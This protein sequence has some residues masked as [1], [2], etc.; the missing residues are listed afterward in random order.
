MLQPGEET[1]ACF[2]KGLFA[3]GMPLND[4]NAP[5]YRRQLEKLGPAQGLD[6]AIGERY[7][8]LGRPALLKDHPKPVGENRKLVAIMEEAGFVR[9]NFLV[10]EIGAK[11][12]A[13]IF[14]I[15]LVFLQE[16]PGVPLGDRVGGQDY[17]VVGVSS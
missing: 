12:A 1:G 6:L 9:L 13:K 4:E 2:Q 10:A 7:L 3:I 11:P 5:A 14:E 16:E 8:G 17:V 15:G